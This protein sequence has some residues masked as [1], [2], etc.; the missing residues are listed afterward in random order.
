MFEEEHCL[1]IHGTAMW[2]QMAP[3]YANTGAD[4]GINY[5]VQMRVHRNMNIITKGEGVQ[6]RIALRCKSCS[7]LSA[8]MTFDSA[9]AGEKFCARVTANCR[10]KNVVYLIECCKCKKLYIGETDNPLRLCM[11]G[12]VSDYYCELSNRTVMEHFNTIGH[13]FENLTVMVIEQIMADSARQKQRE[14][15]GCTPF[16]A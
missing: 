12:H 8:G 4:P 3:S 13:S 11:N 14:S 2:A 10:T 6:K 16:G 5:E 7:H 9:R 15:F 1:Q